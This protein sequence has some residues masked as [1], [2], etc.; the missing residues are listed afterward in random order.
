M[1]NSQVPKMSSDHK[2]FL[3]LNFEQWL[4]WLASTAIAAASI[5]YTAAMVF[6][7]KEDAHIQVTNQEIR[8]KETK[9]DV[10]KRLDRIELKIDKLQESLTFKR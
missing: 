8:L 7:T 2:P 3:G 5:S 6:Q 10:E 4:P 9:E 1:D